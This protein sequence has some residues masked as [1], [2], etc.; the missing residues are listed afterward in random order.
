MNP[1][2]L[3][4]LDPDGAA[5]PKE[6]EKPTAP[7]DAEPAA[8][9]DARDSERPA[10]AVVEVLEAIEPAAWM[11]PQATAHELEAAAVAVP[12]ERL[13][14]ELDALEVPEALA[15]PRLWEAPP[16]APVEEPPAVASS[17]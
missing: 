7:S 17:P 10:T 6:P 16:A 13:S 4:S 5:S 11:N 1:E 9:A 3:A 2:Q 15:V 12:V 14:P 8:A